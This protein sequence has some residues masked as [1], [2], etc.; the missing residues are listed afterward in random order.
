MHYIWSGEWP[1]NRAPRLESMTL[2]GRVATDNIRVPAGQP[3]AVET[4]A[5]DPDGDVLTYTWD[6][7]PEST[8]L[9]EGGDFETTP[10][11]IPGLISGQGEPQATLTAPSASGAYRL[12]VYVFDGNDNAAHA[13][14]PFFVE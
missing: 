4:R 13:N 5:T 1:E 11:S 9:G 3:V 8:D 10:E 12:F 2:D 7:K 14:I 6:L